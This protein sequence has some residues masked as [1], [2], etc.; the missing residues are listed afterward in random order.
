MRYI[1]Q[2]YDN[3]KWRDRNTHAR[4]YLAYGKAHQMID[5]QGLFVRVVVRADIIVAR[6]PKPKKGT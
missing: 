3:N 1:I 2:E 6:F 5:L 4:F